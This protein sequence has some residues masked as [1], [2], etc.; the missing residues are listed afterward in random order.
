MEIDPATKEEFIVPVMFEAFF[1]RG[2]N[3]QEHSKLNMNFTLDDRGIFD[4]SQDEIRSFLNHT[5][6]FRLRYLLEHQ[7]HTEK[8]FINDCFRWE[9]TQDFDFFYR[10]HLIER[11]EFNTYPCLFT[12]ASQST[13]MTGY[14]YVLLGYMFLLGWIR[15]QNT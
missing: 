9:I 13:F 4:K 6:N 3:R 2:E 10:N 14:R 7:L 8:T 12:N 1:L 15:F 5:T 11:F